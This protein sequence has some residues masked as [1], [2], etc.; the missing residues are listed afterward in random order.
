MRIEASF[1]GGSQR[2]YVS[3]R[4]QNILSP[5]IIN[6]EKI[7][8]NTFHSNNSKKEI[9]DYVELSMKTEKINK[10]IKV[11]CIS[12]IC[13]SLKNQPLKF[14]QQTYPHLKNLDFADSSRI[15]SREIDILT[16]SDHLWE[17]VPGKVKSRGINTVFGYVLSG[18]VANGEGIKMNHLNQSSI[19]TIHVSLTLEGSLFDHLDDVIERGCH[20]DGQFRGLH[21]DGDGSNESSHYDG[22][23]KGNYLERDFGSVI[24]MVLT[25][26]L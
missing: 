4:V 9:R 1:D 16:G 20:F 17:I 10:S 5:E 23:F 19:T 6:K 13:L 11:F 14:A 22:P 24:F 25:Q 12:L 15:G 7:K 3:K 18:P 21:L 2:S 8:I 26:K